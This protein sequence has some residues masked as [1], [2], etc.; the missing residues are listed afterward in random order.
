[1]KREEAGTKSNDTFSPTVTSLLNQR[2]AI[3]WSSNAHTA[4]P[5]QVFAIGRGAEAF[6]GF[7]DN[8]DIAKKIM[9]LAGLKPPVQ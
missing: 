8:T 2:A 5:V 3:G 1:M 6:M 4:V 9:Q 7:Y